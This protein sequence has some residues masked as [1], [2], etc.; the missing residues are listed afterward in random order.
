MGPHNIYKASGNL[1]VVMRVIKINSCILILLAVGKSER[2][3]LPSLT[4]IVDRPNSRLY[5]IGGCS[6]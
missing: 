2:K 5:P 1:I 3:L 4:Y 6:V